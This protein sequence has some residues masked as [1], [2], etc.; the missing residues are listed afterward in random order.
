MIISLLI[1]LICWNTLYDYVSNISLSGRELIWP[2][3]K[4]SIKE[5]LILGTGYS[6]SGKYLLRGIASNAFNS[7]LTIIAEE[8]IVGIILFGIF[9]IS[10]LVQLLK[11][12]NKIKNNNMV[13]FAFSYTIQLLVVG[14]VENVWM[15]VTARYLFWIIIYRVSIETEN[16]KYT[17]IENCKY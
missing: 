7:Y 2:I 8:G 5:H 13:I 12:Y 17:Y 3:M 14:M 16:K 15:N 4:S 9:Y 11:T 1:I 10:S 6:S